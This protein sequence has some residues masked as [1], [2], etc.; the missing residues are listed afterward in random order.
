MKQVLQ[1]PKGPKA[2][3]VPVVKEDD[4]GPQVMLGLQGWLGEMA[5]QARRECTALQVHQDLKDSRALEARRELLGTLVYL[6][7]KA[8]R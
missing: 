8:C 5:L 6:D 1:V 7:R 2:C 3:K 4:P